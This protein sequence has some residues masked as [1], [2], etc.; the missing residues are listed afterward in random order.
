MLG[1]QSTYATYWSK[2]RLIHFKMGLP[3]DQKSVLLSTQYV[4]VESTNTLNLH[5]LGVRGVHELR[6]HKL[7][8][9]VLTHDL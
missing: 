1:L 5:Y 6:F 7:F 4:F 2:K 3:S 8:K 9:A